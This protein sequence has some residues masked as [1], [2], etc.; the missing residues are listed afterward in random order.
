MLTVCL[1]ADLKVRL[2]SL[3]EHVTSFST[4]SAESIQLACT[5]V[6]NKNVLNP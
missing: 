3:Q 2:L 6:S 4:E 5:K 1:F